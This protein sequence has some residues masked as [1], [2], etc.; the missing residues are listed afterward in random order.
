MEWLDKPAEEQLLD[1]RACLRTI[2]MI[3]SL[4][5]LGPDKAAVLP[6][7]SQEEMAG[8]FKMMINHLLPEKDRY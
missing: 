6:F 1:I 5:E 8:F 4:Y 2:S 3:M 7:K